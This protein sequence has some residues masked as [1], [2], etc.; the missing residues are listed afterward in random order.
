MKRHRLAG[1]LKVIVVGLCAVTLFT[2]LVMTLWNALL[3]GILGVRS[4]SFWQALGLLVLSKILF[5][6][7]RPGWRGGPPWRRRMTERWE[8]MSPEEREKFKQGLGRGCGRGSDVDAPI[9]QAETQA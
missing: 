5:G 9:R 2:F 7:F 8:R 4:I 3:P 1:V 6:G